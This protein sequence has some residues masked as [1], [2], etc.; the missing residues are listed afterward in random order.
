MQGVQSSVRPD[1]PTS[2]SCCRTRARSTCP[3]RRLSSRP[4]SPRKP[5]GYRDRL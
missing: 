5:H 4:V 3:T 1:G 2:R